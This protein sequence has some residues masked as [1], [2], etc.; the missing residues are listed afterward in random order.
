M[1][2]QT[3]IHPFAPVW[4][5][6]SRVLI[7]GSFPSA[8]SREVGFY[9]GHPRNRFWAVLARVLSEGSTPQTIPERREL[10]LRHGVAL[11]DALASCRIVGSSDQSIRQPVPNDIAALLAQAPIE[12]VFCNG[13][14]AYEVYQRFCAPACGMAAVGLPSTSP[15]NAAWTLERLTEAWRVVADYAISDVSSRR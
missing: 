1:Q 12:R 7:L 2:P 4:N 11:W 9:Y 5:E 8:R 14:R 10:A 13:Q 6:H 3:Q 15:A